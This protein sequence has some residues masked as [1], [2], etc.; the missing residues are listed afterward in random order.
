MNN[1]TPLF[2]PPHRWN[3]SQWKS[4]TDAL[5]GG[6]STAWLRVSL[7]G[8]YALFE[9]TLDSI[10]LGGAGFSSVVNDGEWNFE[11]KDGLWVEVQGMKNPKKTLTLLLKNEVPKEGEGEKE[12]EKPRSTVS[13]EYEIDL[14][15]TASTSSAVGPD[16][17]DEEGLAPM[18][19]MFMPFAEFKPF[20]RGRPVE[21]EGEGLKLG[22]VKRV[23]LMVR[24]YFGRQEQEGA[25]RFTI[26]RVW[27]GSRGR[28][29]SAC[30]LVS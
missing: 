19:R 16:E 15:A 28:L 21:P 5:R 30:S 3:A 20:Y 23:G 1:Y 29:Y 22:D 13:W 6:V 11:G 26:L 17:E 27:A 10:A 9:G 24:S 18:L 2:G 25:F 14:T 7:D 8:T 4:Q 12:K